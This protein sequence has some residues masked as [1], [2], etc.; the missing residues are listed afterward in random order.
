MSQ[1]T[2][3]IGPIRMHK[4][5]TE[6]NIRKAAKIEGMTAAAFM[7]QASERVAEAVIVK[8]EIEKMAVAAAKMREGK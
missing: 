4:K 7:R 6:A 5:P 1:M 2:G 8:F 3:Q